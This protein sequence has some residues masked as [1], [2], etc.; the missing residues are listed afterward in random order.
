V[1]NNASTPIFQK[2][3]Y[4][5]MSGPNVPPSMALK[6]GW[7]LIGHTSTQSMPVESAL[8]SI[9][10]KYSHLLTYSPSEGWK[11]YIVGNPY[12]QQFSAFES[13]KGYWIFMIEDATYAAVDI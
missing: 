4:R 11:M 7:N 9:K 5:N 1:F 3:N 2:L 10:G 8:I 12:L 6:S 13:G